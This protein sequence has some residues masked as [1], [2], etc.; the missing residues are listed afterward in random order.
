MRERRG[1][2][3]RERSFGWG[4]RDKKRREKRREK[5]LSDAVRRLRQ[6]CCHAQVCTHLETRFFVSHTQP[7][8]IQLGAG[9]GFLSLRENIL[10]MS[11]LLSQMIARGE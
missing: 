7:K 10:S 9:S 4:D 3:E 6:A 5:T 11:Q 1:G 2:R 8:T